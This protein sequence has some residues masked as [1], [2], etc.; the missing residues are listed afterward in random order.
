[1]MKKIVPVVI[2]S[3][4][5]GLEILAFQHPLAGIQLVKGTIER[6]EPYE[7][8]AVRE[9]FEESGL[10]AEPNPKFIGNLAVKLSRQ[11]WYFYVC[12]IRTEM[13]EMWIHH[14]QDGGGLD[15]EFFW[16]PL[17]QQ[18][19][20]NWHITFQEALGFIKEKQDLF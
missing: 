17:Y 5:Q 13:P 4:D 19:D 14:C 20:D 15:F 6:D 12:Q 1:M 2:R 18:P 9:L 11:D 16:H 8:A 10:V 3:S 7:Q